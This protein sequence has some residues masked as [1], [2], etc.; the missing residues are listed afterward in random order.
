MGIVKNLTPAGAQYLP[1]MS[2]VRRGAGEDGTGEMLRTVVGDNTTLNTGTTDLPNFFL[3]ETVMALINGWRGA[4]AWDAGD[5]VQ[6]GNTTD[7]NSKWFNTLTGTGTVVNTSTQAGYEGCPLGTT[8]STTGNQN[9]HIGVLGGLAT[10]NRIFVYKQR[11]Y[12]PDPNVTAYDVLGGWF[13]KQ[14]NPGTGG[15]AP[16]DG[17]W[18]SGITAG[19]SMPLLGNMSNNSTNAQTAA[20]A[21]IASGVPRSLE[22][23]TVLQGGPGGGGNNVGGVDFYIRDPSSAANKW[24]NA[25]SLSASA[26]VPRSTIVLR[27]HWVYYTRKVSTSIALNFET[28]FVWM[29]RANTQ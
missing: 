21:T 14:V 19:G 9:A 11:V 10:T 4:S 5:I 22:I 6:Q 18:I 17:A 1:A 24:S 3:P 28:P 12:F 8:G 25:V 23:C 27:P 29:A 15:T 13:N 26:N 2:R 16:T 20:L 7:G